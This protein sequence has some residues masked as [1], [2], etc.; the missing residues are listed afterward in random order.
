[1]DIHI[2]VSTPKV[3]YLGVQMVLKAAP[4]G[5][6]FDTLR[7]VKLVFIDKTPTILVTI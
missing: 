3:V 1:M 6:R 5:I 4:E 2:P 7:T